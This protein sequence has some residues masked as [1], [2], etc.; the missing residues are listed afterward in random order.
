MNTTIRNTTITITNI[1]IINTAMTNTKTRKRTGARLALP[2]PTINDYYI[3]NYDN[4]DK[5][6]SW[7]H[8]ELTALTTT[9]MMM[10]K[11]IMTKIATIGLII[12]L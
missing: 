8:F 4:N 11:T 5:N 3:D 12:Q 10:I 9:A 1:A 7:T 2:Q 6:D